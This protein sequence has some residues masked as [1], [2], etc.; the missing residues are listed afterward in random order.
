MGILDLLSSSLATR[1]QQANVA[2]AQR[3]LADPNLLVEIAAGLDAKK[4]PL[5]ADCA[6]VLTK[7]AEQNP[8]LVAPFAE[9]LWERMGHENGRVRWE[10]AHALALVT[11]LRPQVAERNL[12]KL[13]EIIRTA[14]G[15]IVRDYA[16]DAVLNYAATGDKA[17]ARALPVIRESLSAW[18]S[19]HAGRALEG[20]A[21]AAKAMP[22]VRVEALELARGFEDHER[23]SGEEGGKGRGARLRSGEEVGPLPFSLLLP[24]VGALLG[25]HASG[26]LP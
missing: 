24:G 8:S 6:E 2:V 1:D 23:G 10:S 3:C 19:K 4:A 14:D 18:E 7:V 5:A 16:V 15:V 21:R 20:L 11:P 12:D 9:K 26:R 13:A 17:F 25:R 22:K